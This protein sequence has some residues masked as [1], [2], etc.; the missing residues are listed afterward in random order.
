MVD[1][2][3]GASL[4]ITLLVMASTRLCTHTDTIS[5]LDAGGN[6]LADFH[7]L[8]NDLVANDHGVI[9]WTPT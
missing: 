1:L 9:C 2:P 3:V 4:A 8:T 7:S 5:D 6:V